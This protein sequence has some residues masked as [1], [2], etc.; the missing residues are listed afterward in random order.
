MFE[1]FKITTRK[2]LFP[3]VKVFSIFHPNI[4]TI[5][6]FCITCLA[7]WIY[8]K[9]IFWLGGIILFLGAIFDVLDG[10]I[11]KS[12]GK[13]S[14]FGAFLDSCL[15]RCSDFAI[16]FGMFWWYL[17]RNNTASIL[18]ILTILGSFLVSYTRA[19]AEGLGC[20]CKVGICERALR[21]PIIIV[22]SFL[23]AN[24]FVSFLWLLVILTGWTTLH[25]IWWVWK[26]ASLE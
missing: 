16:L 19:R 5:I 20:E 7:G 17:G 24:I 14:K 21:I 10:E 4:L 1:K 8:S 3:L 11:A 25:R 15:D 26:K 9:G 23:G 18:S 13:A 12:T 6:G 22:G 2:S